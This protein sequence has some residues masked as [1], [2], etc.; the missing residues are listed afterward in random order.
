[1]SDVAN[2]AQFGACLY[3]HFLLVHYLV[4]SKTEI[5]R[6]SKHAPFATSDISLK[7]RNPL[8]YAILPAKKLVKTRHP[9]TR[10][11]S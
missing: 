6:A 2:G 7:L 11:L 10:K 3:A 5:K 4:I 9:S 1:M 8:S